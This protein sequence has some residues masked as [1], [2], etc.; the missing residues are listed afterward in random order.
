MNR[1]HFAILVAMSTAGCVSSGRYDAAAKDAADAHAALQAEHMTTQTLKSRAD[2][3]HKALDEETAQNAE[4]RGELEK[5]GKN[6]DTLLADKGTLA[7][8][9]AESRARLDELRRAQV[10]AETRA[11]LYRDLALRLKKMVDSGDLSIALRDGRMVLQLPNDVLFESGQV[12]MRPRG[13]TALKQVAVVLKT[14]AGRHFQV[15]GHTDNV[16]IDTARFP[17]NWEL[18]SARALE[19]VR[20]LAQQGVSPRMLSAA[21]YG[22]FDPVAENDEAKGRARNRRIEITLQPNVDEIVAMPEGR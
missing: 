14:I 22:E 17:S 15:A 18:S 10:L 11:Q 9:L 3:L 2:T 4:L 1:L 19:V 6:A 12:D 16:P 20:F 5:L 7:S 8:A 21:G 13:Q